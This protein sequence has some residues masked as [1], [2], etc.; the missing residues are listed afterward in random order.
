M[1]TLAIG[2]SL[3]T[4]AGI[5]L[6]WSLV[7]TGIFKVDDLIPGYR[8]WFMA[9]PLA[10]S[11]IAIC[12]LLA[13]IFLLRGDEKAVLFGLLTASGLIFLGLYAL[14]YGINTGLIFNLTADEVIE[15]LIKAYCLS[16]GCFFIFY[17]WNLR[18][19][20]TP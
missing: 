17:F 6:Y 15:I 18:T 9:F 19:T 13:G 2:L 10:D 16:V 14:L 3:F 4:I 11:W 7:F 12:A 1:K 5:A 20:I 8:S